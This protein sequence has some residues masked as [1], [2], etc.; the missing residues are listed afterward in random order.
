M[1]KLLIL[2]L[3]STL[4]LGACGFNDDTNNTQDSNKNIKKANK[5]RQM[6]MIKSK[7][8]IERNNLK[9]IR[10]ILAVR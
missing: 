3:T 6:V 10:V 5:T 7:V 9:L 8:E 2:S 1:K 4:L